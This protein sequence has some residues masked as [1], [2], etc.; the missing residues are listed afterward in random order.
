MLCTYSPPGCLAGPTYQDARRA[1]AG[2]RVE[3]QARYSEKAQLDSRDP[4]TLPSD[5]AL[6][7]TEL[8]AS[9]RTRNAGALQQLY[10]RHF[11][12]AYAVAFRMLGEAGAAEDCVHDQFLKLWQ[13]PDLYDARR[14]VFIYWFLTT[15]HN[16][17]S[18]YLRRQGRTRPLG[19][20][21]NEEEPGLTP[22]PADRDAGQSSVEDLADQAEAQQVVRAALAELTSQQRAVL[23]LA[24]FGGMSQSEIAQYL[25]EPLGT[26]K[27][28]IRTG[29]IKL[30]AALET[31]GWGKDMG[32]G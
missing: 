32:F 23:E 10:D 25:Q 7:D 21:L 22:E 16:N 2:R 24:Y 9:V 1:A 19:N 29:M 13:K 3:V 26:V 28:R 17:A 8:M 31:R 14:G 11:R 30:R 4:A 20:P 12:R 6:S 18:N 15:V 27:T 5:T